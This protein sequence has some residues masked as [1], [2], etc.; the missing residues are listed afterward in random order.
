MGKKKSRGP[1]K[2]IS[3]EEALRRLEEIVKELEE[4]ELPLEKSLEVF[5]E[6]VRLSRQLNQKLSEAEKKV[7][8]LLRNEAG[9]KVSVPFDPERS[10]P[11]DDQE[12]EENPDEQGGLPF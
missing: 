5:E 4:A 1:G 2:E 8:I 11:A 6:G 3:F 12:E 9:E 10:G 7:E